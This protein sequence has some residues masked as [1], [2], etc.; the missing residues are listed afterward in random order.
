M[1]VEQSE[2]M[3]Q[4]YRQLIGSLMYLVNTRPDICFAVN[5]LSQF[6][7]ELTR[8]HWVA[9]KHV[10]RYLKRHNRLWIVVQTG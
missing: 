9:V 4:L 2:W 1:L 6:M 7:M 8:V 10:L 5:Q 3:L